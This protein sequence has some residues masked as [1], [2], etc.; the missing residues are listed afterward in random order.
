M[1]QNGPKRTPYNGAQKGPLSHQFVYP[2]SIY[3]IESGPPGAHPHAPLNPPV[4]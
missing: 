3:E 4:V 1:T 2:H